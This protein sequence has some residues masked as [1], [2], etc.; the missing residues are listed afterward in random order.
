MA[1][2]FGSTSAKAAEEAGY[3]HPAQA[4]IKLIKYPDVRGR[5]AELQSMV[6]VQKI[7]AFSQV[8]MP[9]K[10]WVM[11][12]LCA[13]VNQAKEAK[14]RGAVNKGLELVGREL[15]MFVQRT[16]AIESPLQRL[17]ADKLLALLA[18]VEEATGMEQVAKPT[19]PRPP[20]PVMIEHE[21]ILEPA[22]NSEEW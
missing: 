11:T 1:V 10:A 15:G 5:L 3:A 21:H 2:A 16:L 17:P 13:N 12:E 6:E 20:E 18:L 7:K 9:T 19:A 8:A 14:D 22:D 4:A